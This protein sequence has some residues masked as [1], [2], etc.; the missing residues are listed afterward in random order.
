M[1]FQKAFNISYLSTNFF[2]YALP[3]SCPFNPSILVFSLSLFN[4][5]LFLLPW[6]EPLIPHDLLQAT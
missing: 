4:T 1:A 5:I 2:L 3:I 6:E